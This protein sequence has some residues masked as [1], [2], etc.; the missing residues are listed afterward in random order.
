MIATALSL[1]KEIRDIVGVSKAYSD[2][3][4]R[5]KRKNATIV[6]PQQQQA[7]FMTRYDLYTMNMDKVR[8][9]Y[10]CENFGYIARY[11]KSK[12]VIEQG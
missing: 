4:E 3:E 11:C 9:C 10:N 12:R 7:E 8:N 6:N 2:R 5:V 1:A